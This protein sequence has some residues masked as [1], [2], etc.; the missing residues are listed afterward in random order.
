VRE[1]KSRQGRDGSNDDPRSFDSDER[2]GRFLK[3]R[4][5][6][7]RTGHERSQRRKGSACDEFLE[8]MTAACAGVDLLVDCVRSAPLSQTISTYKQSRNQSFGA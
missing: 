7:S 6:A 4:R 8:K 2:E 1:S 5:M 3:L